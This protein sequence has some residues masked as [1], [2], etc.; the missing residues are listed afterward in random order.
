[1]L[2]CLALLVLDGGELLGGELILVLGLSGVLNWSDGFLDTTS[3][4]PPLNTLAFSKASSKI[5]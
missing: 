5:F 3:W 4:F 2:Y 1:M